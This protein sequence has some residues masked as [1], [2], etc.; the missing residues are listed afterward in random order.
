MRGLAR[1]YDVRIAQ[2]VL[3]IEKLS[4]IMGLRA[5]KDIRSP[6]LI[7]APGDI[8]TSEIFQKNLAQGT[9]AGH[10]RDRN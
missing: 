9:R 5:S 1:I 6:S 3:K 8:H 2:F 4:H 10:V 7:M